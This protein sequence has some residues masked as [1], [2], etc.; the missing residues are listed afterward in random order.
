MHAADDEVR[1]GAAPI[2]E[3]P[4]GQHPG[5]AADDEEDRQ[6]L[7]Q[8][9]HRRVPGRPDGR[10]LEHR[11]VRPHG[12]AHLEAVEQHDG[13]DAQR[14]DEVDHRVTPGGGSG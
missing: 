7:Q 9:G 2:A 4:E 5:E 6:H 14:A 11:A 3:P 12:D 1:R 8:P 13:D 10:V